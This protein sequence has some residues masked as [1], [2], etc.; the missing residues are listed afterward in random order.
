MYEFI[1]AWMIKTPAKV[2]INAQNP[3][4]RLYSSMNHIKMRIPAN[5]IPDNPVAIQTF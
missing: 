5:P 4:K 1:P 3:G 2:G